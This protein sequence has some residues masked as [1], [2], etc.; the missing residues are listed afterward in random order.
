MIKKSV[1]EIYLLLSLFGIS[2]LF[3][4]IFVRLFLIF[5]SFIIILTFAIVHALQVFLD[6]EWDE[7][8]YWSNANHGEEGPPDA[9]L[10]VQK[11]ICFRARCSV[12]INTFD[13]KCK[14]E[15]YWLEEATGLSDQEH[16]SIDQGRL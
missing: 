5:V 16:R 4:A 7:E 11:N 2:D 8:G 6:K 3:E 10:L 1:A 12:I 14:C 13:V 15:K 9:V